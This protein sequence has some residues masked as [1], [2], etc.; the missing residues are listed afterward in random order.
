MQMLCSFSSLA[1]LA[2]WLFVIGLCAGAALAGHVTGPD[3]RKSPVVTCDV[4]NAAGK[5]VC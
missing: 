2:L 4:G 1:R 3:A 5:G